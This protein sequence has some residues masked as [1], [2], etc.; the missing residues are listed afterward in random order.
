M[1]A[2]GGANIKKNHPKTACVMIAFLI[3]ARDGFSQNNVVFVTS[4]TYTT[5]QI[6]SIAGA[7]SLCQAHATS[8]NLPGIFKAWLSGS[9]SDASAR[10]G[11]A[12]GF[13]RIDGAPVADL[14]DRK[15]K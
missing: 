14:L 2:G 10:L 15:S 13:V 5:T 4:L 8:V 3:F 6:G 11:A 1:E 7:D 9:T 12:R